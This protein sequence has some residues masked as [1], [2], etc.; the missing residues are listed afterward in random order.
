MFCW[1]PATNFMLAENMLKEEAQEHSK[2][3]QPSSK[4]ITT[5]LRT[6]LMQKHFRSKEEKVKVFFFLTDY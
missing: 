2:T 1:Q 3:Q 4:E 5:P 6:R